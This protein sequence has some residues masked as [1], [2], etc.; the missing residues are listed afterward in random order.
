VAAF[1]LDRSV[2]LFGNAVETDFHEANDAKNEAERK[3]KV[4]I[5]L[6]KWFGHEAVKGQ[7]ANPSPTVGPGKIVSL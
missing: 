7:F 4:A 1:C 2:A 6:A 3:R 5:V